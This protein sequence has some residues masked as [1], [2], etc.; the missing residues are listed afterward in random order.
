[1]PW[2][3]SPEE[4]LHLDQVPKHSTLQQTHLQHHQWKTTPTTPTPTPTPTSSS[5]PPPPPRRPPT[6]PPSPL[7]RI[8]PSWRRP[9]STFS[10]P[11][12][13]SSSSRCSRTTNAT[14]SSRST[15]SRTTS[16]PLARIKKIMKA[17]EDVMMISEE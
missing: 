10:R 14:R 12:N 13:S 7:C 11:S 2:T 3:K 16:S 17:D 5:S 6:H 1:M 15:I 9:S 4:H 8:P